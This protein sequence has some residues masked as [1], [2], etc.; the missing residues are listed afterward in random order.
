[1]SRFRYPFDFIVE[2]PFAMNG[3]NA[4]SPERGGEFATAGIPELVSN[5]FARED[6]LNRAVIGGVS[7]TATCFVADL[8]LI[9]LVTVFLTVCQKF[10]KLFL[11]KIKALS[12]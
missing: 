7:D 10:G 4:I 2:Q 1:M 6:N 11:F 5:R 8:D 9:S 3:R 12:F